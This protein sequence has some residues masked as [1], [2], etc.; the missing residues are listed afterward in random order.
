MIFS[1]GEEKGNT[2][3]A[4]GLHI[5]DH[6]Q[7][8]WPDDNQNGCEHAARRHTVYSVRIAAK[9]RGGTHRRVVADRVCSE[10]LM[11]YQTPFP[12]SRRVVAVLRDLAFPSS[13]ETSIHLDD[14]FGVEVA[15]RI[16]TQG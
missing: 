7:C 15:V 9:L 11:K 8:E 6:H 16:F 4:S 13:L 1:V 14:D 10:R 2:E 12:R 5:A 3:S